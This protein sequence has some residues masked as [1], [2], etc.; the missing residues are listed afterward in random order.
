MAITPTVLIAT[1]GLLQGKGIAVSRTLQTLVS[2]IT[3]NPVITTFSQIQSGGFDTSALPSNLLTVLTTAGP[4]STES[5]DQAKAVFGG[6]LGGTSESMQVFVGNFSGASAF[7]TASSEFAAA[8]NKFKNLSFTDLGINIQNYTDVVTNGVSSISKELINSAK[9]ASV[10]VT[11]A[12]VGAVPDAAV[13]AAD[14]AADSVASGLSAVGEGLKNFGSI[15][16]F[17][18]V[19]SLG[20]ANMVRQLQRQGLAKKYG[21]DENL[22]SAGYDPAN[23]FAIPDNVL[24]TAL[25]FVAG[26]DKDAVLRATN[27]QLAN[28]VTNLAQVLV[29]SNVLPPQAL[30]AMGLLGNAPDMLAKF[31]SSL[32]NLGTQLDNF[33]MANY[34]DS[35]ETEA[36]KYLDSLTQ[37]IPTSIALILPPFLG[38][39][40][41]T[42]GNPKIKD[43]IGVAAGAG[44]ND[45]FKAV[46]QTL[47]VLASSPQ[48]QALSTASSVYSDARTA[49]A[50]AWEEAGGEAGTDLTLEEYVT[51]ATLVE[52]TALQSAINA[53]PNAINAELAAVINTAEQA[54]VNVAENL[55]K[56]VENLAQAGIDLVE[57]TVDNVRNLGT[58]LMSFGNRLHQFGLDVQNM[59][60][61]ELLYEMTTD[62]IYGDAIKA[63]LMEGRNLYRNAGVRKPSTT[64]SD[65]TAELAEAQKANLPGLK[66]AYQAADTRFARAKAALF[67]PAA[68]TNPAIN[69][70]YEAAK[71]AK[72]QAFTAVSAAARQSETPE[73]AVSD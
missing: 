45:N 37:L 9:Q 56:E 44:Y 50:V 38:S 13:V 48:G 25:S 17:R 23:V 68:K 19:N 33:S 30:V 73:S 32:S 59:G 24:T 15:L 49:A 54:L 36:L 12:V 67:T 3:N 57:N 7:A 20:P 64:E 51:G 58:T 69:T 31:G 6:S 62:D 4:R 1:T 2:D 10:E 35:V 70:E 22:I 27:T 29:A 55:I 5:L 40:D 43:L 26:E 14:A 39:G 11:A 72:H 66:Q 65:A 21:I 52:H 41:G 16:D 46:A 71:S 63:C 34:L 28:E 47:E 61:E 8:L 53:I 42:F 18:E 60:Y